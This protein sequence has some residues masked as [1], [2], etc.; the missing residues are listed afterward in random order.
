[1]FRHVSRTKN[2]LPAIYLSVFFLSLHYA[3][4]IYI[5]SSFLSGHFGART[6]G[7]IYTL[8]SLC[9]IVTLSVIPRVLRRFGNYLTTLFFGGAEILIL[10]TLPYLSDPILLAFFFIMHANIVTLLLFSFDVFTESSSKDETTGTTRGIFLTTI[11]FAIVLG[12]IMGGLFITDGEF[13]K[14]YTLSAL[15]MLPALLVAMLHFRNFKDPK[16]HELKWKEAVKEVWRDKDIR[17]IF[18]ANF[19]L[20]FF[21]SWMI[22]YLPVYL[23]THVGFSWSE[24]GVIFGIMLLPFVLFELPLGEIADKRLG[25]KEILIA[26]FFIMAISTFSLSFI[27]TADLVVWTILLF[28][29]RIGAAAVE[30]MSETYFFK[31]ISAGDTNTLSSFRH[32]RP[33]AFVAG[34]LSASVFLSFFDIKYLFITLGI[35]MLVGIRFASSI[36]DTR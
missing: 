32:T 16:Y 30:I 4:T 14:V 2:L 20:Q 31:K 33:L 25:E 24:I 8:G 28:F 19:L 5:D 12:P 22:I 13:S 27:T 9:T 17:F 15:F 3:I 11:N 34:T 36:N 29:T 21:Y 1:M 6:I 7:L 26:G 35:L 23:N 10:L 18:G